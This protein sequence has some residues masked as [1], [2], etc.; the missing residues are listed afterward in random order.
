MPRAIA[1]AN[2]D[3][4][5]T[6]LSAPASRGRDQQGHCDDELGAANTAAS[7]TRAMSSATC[8]AAPSARAGTHA[9]IAGEVLHGV[10]LG[11]F[12]QVPLEHVWH[13]PEQAVL[14]HTPPTQ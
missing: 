7:A 6:A 11:W 8:T 4:S 1:A 10:P 9:A 13:K 3:S 14:Q 12:W 5:A 2:I